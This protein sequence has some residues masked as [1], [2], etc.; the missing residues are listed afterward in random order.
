MNFTKRSD[1]SRTN[2]LSIPLQFWL[3]GCRCMCL[4]PNS[5][6]SGRDSP[7]ETADVGPA[8]CT[9][10]EEGSPFGMH[11]TPEERPLPPDHPGG[12]QVVLYQPLPFAVEFECTAGADGG[13]SG[14]GGSRN[15]KGGKEL[16]L[17]R[18]LPF[19]MIVQETEGADGGESRDG[20]SAR[21]V[22]SDSMGTSVTL[23]TVLDSAQS[24]DNGLSSAREVSPA[25][26]RWGNR[27]ITQQHLAVVGVVPAI[28]AE[29]VV[30]LLCRWCSRR[31]RL[32][33]Q[34]L[35]SPQGV[36]KR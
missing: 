35:V 32:R 11:T 2:T 7:R 23:E 14:D 13:E 21:A 3:L 17:Y 4:Q 25:L 24:D 30:L 22:V 12:K 15:P 1:V 16:M 6:V 33:Q 19:G 26:V 18:P 31:T 10:E 9:E 27:R 29:A 20:G 5:A 28:F 8:V 34:A 36:L